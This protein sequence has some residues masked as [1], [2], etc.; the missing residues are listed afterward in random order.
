MVKS[1]PFTDGPGSSNIPMK[2]HGMMIQRQIKADLI[3]F[4][5]DG[6]L[7][8][9]SEDIAWCANKTLEAIGEPQM[10]VDA[11]VGHIG[12]G[13]RPLLE[14]LLPAKSAQEIDAARGLF[15]GFYGGHLVVKT[16]LYPGVVDT[17]DHFAKLSKPMAVVTN[18]P[19]SLSV[20]ILEALGLSGY[21]KA[22]L[23]GDSVANKKP[24]P[25][26]VEK[27]IRDL[28]ATPERSV[29][30]GDSPVDCEAAIAAGAHSIGVSYGFRGAKELESAGCEMIIDDFSSLRDILV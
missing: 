16:R 3:I 22:V 21:F 10:P 7:V 25:E 29:L 27:V 23:G 30:V 5:L 28:S 17:L 8:D 24:H 11:I 9:S 19:Y 13:V 4:D 18:K 20:G 26:P 14:K 2:G 15:L 12:W 6:T 1:K